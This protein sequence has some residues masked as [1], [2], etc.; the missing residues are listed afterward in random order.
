MLLSQLPKQSDS[1]ATNADVRE[2]PPVAMTAD[3]SRRALRPAPL[4]SALEITVSRSSDG[5]VVR[6]KGEATVQCASALLDGLLTT[7][8]QRP[9]VVTLDLTELRSIS[10]LA[11]GVLVTYRRGV[12]RKGGQVRLVGGLQPVVQEALARTKLLDLFETSAIAA[13]A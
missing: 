12:V 2:R 10:C 8:T 1:P 5:L 11:M 13:A 7:T 3:A 6:V 4:A 9:A